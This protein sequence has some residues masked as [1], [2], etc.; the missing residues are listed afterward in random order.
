M[1]DSESDIEALPLE[2]LL[3]GAA[4]SPPAVRVRSETLSLITDRRRSTDW[5]HGWQ[6]VI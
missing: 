4:E 2:E 1:T 3:I 6:Q 5:C